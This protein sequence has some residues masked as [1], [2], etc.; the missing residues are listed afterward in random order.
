MATTNA[1]TAGTFV[2]SGS[3]FQTTGGN[4]RGTNATDLQA[5]R[6]TNTQVASGANSTIIGGRRNVA[7]NTYSAVLGGDTNTAS[8]LR[9]AIVGGA[10]STASGEDAISVGAF[11]TASGF[12]SMVF[13]RGSTASGSQSLTIGNGS[14]ASGASDATALGFGNTVNNSFATAV[15]RNNLVSGSVAF[16]AGNANTAS[17]SGSFAIGN[18]IT[19]SGTNT[20]GTYGLRSNTTET[21]VTGL[22]WKQGQQVP[23][24]GNI[25][26]GSGLSKSTSGA[27]VTITPSGVDFEILV[28]DGITGNNFRMIFTNGVLTSAVAE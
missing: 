24:V 12:R 17:G 2:R 28:N 16:A 1:M 27:N 7:S 25:L 6:D 11:S 5:D 23:H 15:G 9:S 20:I 10:F 22:L 18:S 8:G 14:T 26:V 21:T 13:G 19:E 3:G 4:A